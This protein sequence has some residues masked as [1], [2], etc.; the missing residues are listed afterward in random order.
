MDVAVEPD[1]GLLVVRTCRTVGDGGDPDL[2]PVVRTTEDVELDEIGVLG[3]QLPEPLAQLVEPRSTV[4]DD[5]SHRRRLERSNGD[6]ATDGR[7]IDSGA[8]GRRAGV[9]HCVDGV[10]IRGLR[11]RC[12]GTRTAAGRRGHPRGATGLPGAG[13]SRRAARSCRLQGGTARQRVGLQVRLGVGTHVADQECPP[14]GG[15]QRT[16]PAGDPDLSRAR[17]SIHRTG[18][19]IGDD[20]LAV[21]HGRSTAKRPTADCGPS[22]R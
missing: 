20:R 22:C 11:T 13:V 5:V 16:R 10:G 7:G 21:V 3:G 2:A 14:G 12:R 6:V 18:P 1:G 8:V 9:V 17:V 19:R 4:E 15:R